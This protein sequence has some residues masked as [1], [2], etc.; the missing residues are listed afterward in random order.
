MKRLLISAL[1]LS[2]SAF[3][4]IIAQST[5]DTDNDG[6]SVGEFFPAIAG[7]GTTLAT[8][9][10]GGFIRTDDS[11][12]WVAFR[13]PS[14][15]LGNLLIHYGGL[16]MFSERVLSSD[17]T[18]FPA[19]ALTSGSTTIQ[20]WGNPPGT[21]W[22]T[23]TIPLNETGW[24]FADGTVS[25]GPPVSSAQFKQVLSNLTALTISAEWRT[26]EDQTD[27]D[28]VTLSSPIPE[29]ST[30]I[31]LVTGVAAVVLRRRIRR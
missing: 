24:Q 19:V 18:A 22:T 12:A 6:W 21:D 10:A 14:K 25:N 15:F 1:L 2:T 5:F 11:Y 27:L 17:G 30:W 26:G 16:L 23:Y 20:Y 31:M 9:N 8:H 28:N 29:P 4:G 3:A 13:A 7:G